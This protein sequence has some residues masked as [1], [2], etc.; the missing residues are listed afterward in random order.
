MPYNTWEDVKP[1]EGKQEFAFSLLGSVD[2][3]L[4]GGARGGGKVCS[5]DQLIQTPWGTKTH[6]D[7]AVGDI[8]LNPDGQRQKVRKVHPHKDWTFY[9]I[10]FSDG[11]SV[12]AGLEHLW[13]SWRASKSTKRKRRLAKEGV[14]VEGINLAPVDAEIVDTE[15]MKAWL[16]AG[17]TPLIPVTKPVIFENSVSRF[18]TIDPYLL[19]Y[20]LGDGCIT[21]ENTLSITRH[22]DD[23]QIDR[24][25]QS[26]GVETSTGKCPYRLAFLGED[27]KNLVACLENLNLLGTNSSTKFIPECYKRGSVEVRTEILKGLM[28]SDGY[29]STDGKYY[30]TSVSKTL[31]DD[32]AFLVR[33]LG[34]NATQTSKEG[35]YRD[36][37][38]DLVHCKEAFELYIKFNKTLK[39]FKLQRK[40][41]RCTTT[42]ERLYKRVVSIEP[43]RVC[44][45]CCIEVSNPNRL[46]LTNDFIVTHNSELLTMIPL[47]FADD[48]YYRGIFFRRQY[49]E[50]MGANGL[51]QKGEG[52]YPLFDGSANISSKTWR[53]P[54]GARQEFRHMYYE[55][56]KESHRGKGYSFIGFDEIDHFSKEQVTFLMTCLRSEAEMSSFMV[57]TLNPN[58]DSWCLPLVEW[59]LD[60]KGQ[61]REDRCGVV[62]YF[63][64]KEGEFL[65]GPSAEWFEEN[66]RE[67]VWVT[68]PDGEE[69]YVRPKTFTYLFF[70][71]FDN[72]EM[73]RLNP[74][75]VSELQN[76]PEHERDSQLWG[77]WYSRPRSES[78]WQRHWVRGENGERALKR[79]QVPTDTVKLRGVDKA[80]SIPSDTYKYPDYTAFSPRIEKDTNGFYYLFGDY[81]SKIIDI[82]YKEA[83]Q[84]VLGRF[85]KLAGERDSL[86]AVQAKHDP[87]D[88]KVVLSK[89]S[90]AGSADHLYTLAK[91]TE[92]RISVVADKTV[93]NVAGKKLKDFIPFA[94]ACEQGLVFIVEDSFHP[95]TLK[96]YYKE[97]ERFDGEGSTSAKKDDWAD[98]TAMTF[99]A[100]QTTK[101]IRIVRRNQ[102]HNTTVAAERL[103]RTDPLKQN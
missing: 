15:T 32:V 102:Q 51:W 91:L 14:T 101:N 22:P 37:N 73:I 49:D 1:Q 26:L 6:G 7:I 2:F 81:N 36:A 94:N 56:D 10:A 74:A 83:D 100:I 63:V 90:G 44:D 69:L 54:T 45:G 47:M 17:H 88:C 12:E 30:Y 93:S 62:R 65:F 67:T 89:D 70:N 77:N 33:S 85:R 9:N 35:K 5:Y 71:V 50:I 78:L 23:Q 60:E 96:A 42:V 72:P 19:G 48:P 20:L 82:K 24:Y 80:H 103:S 86:I 40:L 21:S 25:I 46:Y 27:K 28:D 53:F 95:E 64:V 8:I 39:P 66:H 55:G 52:M 79:H 4:M 59:Y 68:L 43:A 84:P 76:L 16:D 92:Q 75:Y 99:N 98:A 18:Q 29:V 58:P 38:G 87:P 13:L 61:P 31:S 11:T 34:G 57:G 3:M 41:D 97:L